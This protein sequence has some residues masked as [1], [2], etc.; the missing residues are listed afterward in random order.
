[1]NAA[2]FFEILKKDSL[3]NCY[4][5]EGEEEYLKE[6][7]LSQLKQKLIMPPMGELNLSTLIDPD[8][9]EII[10]VCETIPLMADSR[11]VIVR[12]SR[13]IQD[14]AGRSKTPQQQDNLADYL[15]KIPKHT[16]LVFFARGKSS[17]NRK[18]PRAIKKAGGQVLFNTM[19]GSALIKWIA[20]ELSKYNKKIDRATAD[21]MIFSCGQ[22]MLVFSN[23]IAKVAAISGENEVISTE[24]IDNICTKTR[25]YKVF[26]LSDAVSGGKS[27]RA[28][29]IMNNLI[30][31]G[32]PR[33]LLLSLLQRQYRQMLFCA[34]LLKSRTS[35]SEIAS[36]LSVPPFVVN[37]LATTIKP[38]TVSQLKRAYEIL[39]ETEYGVKSGEIPEEGSLEKAVFTLLSLSEKVK[40]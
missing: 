36:V 23:E 14:S 7:A 32:E 22:D 28:I 38:Y 20:K 1:M 8:D 3:S 17:G 39:I 40:Q 33:M 5:F 13:F 25:E 35:Y 37:K 27:A 2:D 21:Y 11:L 10:S 6:S 9:K 4:L 30:S 15:K 16:V 29:S 19:T 31:E 26:D 34:I 12:E 24:D 18:I